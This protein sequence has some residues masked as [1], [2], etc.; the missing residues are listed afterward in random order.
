MVVFSITWL[1]T[2]QIV[3][4]LHA[5]PTGIYVGRKGNLA[6]CSMQ[7]H[8]LTACSLQFAWFIVDHNSAVFGQLNRITISVLFELKLRKLNS[9]AN[10]IWNS[11]I[12]V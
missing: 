7:Q 12:G 11:S 2:D 10:S 3:V 5:S 8:L 1:K 4:L 6:P 9:E